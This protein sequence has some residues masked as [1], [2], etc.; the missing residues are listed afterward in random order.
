MNDQT[1]LVLSELKRWST[2]S[3]AFHACQDQ[4]I[5]LE[6]FHLALEELWA[7]GLTNVEFDSEDQSIIGAKLHGRSLLTEKGHATIVHS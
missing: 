5:N 3:E 2:L 7:N 4:G 6:D 1:R